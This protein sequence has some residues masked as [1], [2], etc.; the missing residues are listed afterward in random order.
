MVVNV[1][2]WGKLKGPGKMKLKHAT[3]G[4]REEQKF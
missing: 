1:D 2:M 4:A 3:H